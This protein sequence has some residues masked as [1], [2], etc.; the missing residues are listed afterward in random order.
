MYEPQLILQRKLERKINAKL[1]PADG[2]DDT[3]QKITIILHRMCGKLL[4]YFPGLLS[5]E[6]NQNS[7]EGIPVEKIK[8]FIRIQ[9]LIK[10]DCKTSLERLIN[11]HEERI[12]STIRVHVSGKSF[13]NIEA[14]QKVFQQ[15]LIENYWKQV[16]AS[17]RNQIIIC[18]QAMRIHQELAQKGHIIDSIILLN[19]PYFVSPYVVPDLMVL[20]EKG[21]TLPGMRLERAMNIMEPIVVR[22]TSN[23]LDQI[24]EI[25]GFS[26]KVFAALSDQ[27]PKNDSSA[28]FKDSPTPLQ[29]TVTSAVPLKSILK[30]KL[31]DSERVQINKDVQ[32]LT[33][34]N[35]RANSYEYSSLLNQTYCFGPDK[36]DQIENEIV[37]KWAETQKNI[38][39]ICDAN[40]FKPEHISEIQIVYETHFS[41]MN[42]LFWRYLIGTITR[43]MIRLRMRTEGVLM[44][45]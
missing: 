29:S 6:T 25:L 43:I 16:F 11:A 19:F 2:P 20:M 4:K 45:D 23:L 5:P 33:D 18:E 3:L 34:D 40:D 42:K 10:N 41:F 27:V 31:Q 30:V 36:I 21:S 37:E 7:S 15:A 17:L 1:V 22:D 39:R 28:R 24:R 35:T 14:I 8:E 12:L 44:D 26:K 38:K 13:Q 32:E 9:Q